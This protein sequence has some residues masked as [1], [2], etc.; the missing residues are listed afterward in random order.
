MSRRSVGVLSG[1]HTL[2]LCSIF[3][4]QSP[5]RFLTTLTWQD[6]PSQTAKIEDCAVFLAAN[7]SLAANIPMAPGRRNSV[8][9]Y[10]WNPHERGIAMPEHRG[11]IHANLQIPAR[12][13]R[14]RLTHPHRDCENGN[15]SWK[16]LWAWETF[17]LV[18]SLFDCSTIIHTEIDPV[19]FAHK[20]ISAISRSLKTLRMG[21]KANGDINRQ[22]EK[23]PQNILYVVE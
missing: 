13:S 16:V 11:Q 3:T 15:E 5:F 1:P 17:L 4:Q 6:L 14:L 8:S 22:T 10:F 12:V 23:E 20:P 2:S 9:P 18:V 21:N 19:P 7:C